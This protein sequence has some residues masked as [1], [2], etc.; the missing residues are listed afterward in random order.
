M[1]EV[2]EE[3]QVKEEEEEEEEEEEQKEEQESGRGVF[4]DVWSTVQH[5]LPHRA[6]E[7]RELGP[8][9]QCSLRNHK[10]VEPSSLELNAML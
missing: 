3:G 5:A 2:E 4:E 6:G 10:R 7:L 9:E 1:E 8:D